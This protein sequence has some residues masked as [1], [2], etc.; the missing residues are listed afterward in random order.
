[1][2]AFS[3]LLAICVGNSP[4]PGES[5]AQRPVTWSLMFSLICARINGWVN[6]GEAGD[7]RRH[8]AHYDVRV[9]APEEATKTIYWDQP[10]TKGWKQYLNATRLGLWISLLNMEQAA[11]TTAKLN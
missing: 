6:S 2:E 11:I 5:P 3:A 1:M 7:L 4:I 10:I 9:M 8:R